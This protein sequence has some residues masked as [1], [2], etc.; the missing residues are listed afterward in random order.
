MEVLSRDMS[1]SRWT[2]RRLLRDAERM[3]AVALRPGKG[4]GRTTEVIFTSA[5][6][7]VP[8]LGF[9]RRLDLAHRACGFQKF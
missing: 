9:L 7:N 6:R 1:M 5:L 4:R 2:L 3:G 8:Q